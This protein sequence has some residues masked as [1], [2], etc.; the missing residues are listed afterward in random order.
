MSIPKFELFACLDD[1]NSVDGYS[2][3]SR[4]LYPK[5]EIRKVALKSKKS[6]LYQFVIFLYLIKF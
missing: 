6:F 2:L 1:D 5:R 4:G 3:Q